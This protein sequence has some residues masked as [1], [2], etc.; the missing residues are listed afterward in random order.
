MHRRRIILVLVLL[1]AAAAGLSAVAYFNADRFILGENHDT[2][3]APAPGKAR[4]QETQV[5][6]KTVEYWVARSPACAGREPE[7][8]VLFFIGKGGRADEWIGGIADSWSAQPVEIWAMNYP[9]SGGSAGPVRGSQVGPDAL[10]LFDTAKAVAG[11]RPIFVQGGSFGTTAALCVAARRP[12]AGLILQNPPPLRQLILGRYGWW[13]LWLAAGPI[14]AQVPDD[15]DSISNA[16]HCS[17]P[18]IFILSGRDRLIPPRYHGQ[19]VS[20][21]AGPKRII[22]MPW[23]GHDDPLTNEAAEAL[24]E[25]KKWL[26]EMAS[27]A[28]LAQNKH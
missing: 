28:R 6:G 16:S 27:T 21:Y 26:W 5:D 13:N 15:L 23:A 14:A 20:A 4:R 2:L 22:D 9:G 1:L 18:A 19:V 24:G 7:G 11:A 3:A 10:A 25:G 8:F 12:V 17:A